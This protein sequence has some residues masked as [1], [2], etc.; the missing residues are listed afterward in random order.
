MIRKSL[1]LIAVILSIPTLLYSWLFYQ[2]NYSVDTLSLQQVKQSH[3]ASATWLISNKKALF[4]SHNPALWEM[5]SKTAN[6]SPDPRLK[7]L[8]KEYRDTNRVKYSGHPLEFQVFGSGYARYEDL[9]L[10][11]FP[12]YN[13][14]MM[15]GYS[16]D[17][18]LAELATI[19]NQ[20]QLNFCDK[21]HPISPAC[22]THQ[23]YGFTYLLKNSCE[24]ASY[25]NEAV[26]HLA[27]DISKQLWFDIRL[28]DVYLQR[29]MML[30]EVN[31]TD[32]IRVNWLHNIIQAQ[33]S[34]G[35]W[36]DFMPLVNLGNSRS[37]GIGS[38][39]FKVSSEKSNFHTTVQGA[40]LTAY[41]MNKMFDET[42]PTR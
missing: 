7:K 6:I 10:S 26:R 28:V 18:T 25:I 3:L 21:N 32:L 16:C 34:D 15:Y 13:L 27:V 37:F 38:K 11:M 31:Q 22:K 40:L 41:A 30:L 29:V 5:L 4:N 39:F 20:K 14:F 24:D 35:G 19:E 12:Y 8:V 9:D 33:H 17:K 23:L 1:W 36:D 42:T 2:N